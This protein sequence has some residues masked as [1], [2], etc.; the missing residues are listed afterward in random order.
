MEDPAVLSIEAAGRRLGIGKTLAYEL[1]RQGVI[2]TLDLGSRRVV[3]VVRLERMLAGDLDA[4]PAAHPPDNGP[5]G[6]AP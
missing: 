5:T 4:V 2:P 6:T 1:A 3:P